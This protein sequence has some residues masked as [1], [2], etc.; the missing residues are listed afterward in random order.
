MDDIEIL[1]IQSVINAI[2]EFNDLKV[3]DSVEFNGNEYPVFGV[4]ANLE[5]WK[6]SIL[7]MKD[8]ELTPIDRD[9]YVFEGWNKVIN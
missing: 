1:L 2:D 4:T 3:K 9:T 7:I 8:D 6:R 5:T